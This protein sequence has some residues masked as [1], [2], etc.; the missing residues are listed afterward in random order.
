MSNIKGKFVFI[1]DNVGDSFVYPADNKEAK[2]YCE[3]RKEHGFGDDETFSLDYT[4]ASFILPRL[5]R[6]REITN[7]S[8]ICV[9]YD[10]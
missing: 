5:R 9:A 2:K 8:P 4:L 6:Y 3:Q 1:P 10:E 7:R